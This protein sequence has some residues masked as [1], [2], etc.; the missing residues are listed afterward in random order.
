M[1]N[2]FHSDE[3][4]LQ[5]I[6][7]I[8][9]NPGRIDSTDR[10][11]TTKTISATAEASGLVNADYTFALTLAAPTDARLVVKSLIT[12]LALTIDSDDGTH[13]LCCRVYADAQDADHLIFDI[14]CTTTGAQ[15]AAQRLTTG[16]KDVLFAS[17]KNGAAHNYYIFFWS[18]GNHSP[19]LSQAQ[20][21]IAVG[22][23][24]TAAWGYEVLSFTPDVHCE[25]Q[26]RIY[27][28]LTG[29][30]A[31]TIIYL[32]NNATSGGVG[33]F[34]PHETGNLSSASAAADFLS[35]YQMLPAGMAFTFT[36]Y[37]SV[38]TDLQA[39]SGFNFIIKRLN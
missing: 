23:N 26:S 33:E 31:Q 5:T 28:V 20:F 19:V 7:Q 36:I 32:L 6:E 4:S 10:I 14:A 24:K 39:I 27:H 8:I 2:K 16:V 3:A 22:T 18:P 37:G 29:T 1:P 12:R 13:D 17:L 9:Y 34:A 35:C 25:M 11:A 21:W 30:G 38:A 15:L